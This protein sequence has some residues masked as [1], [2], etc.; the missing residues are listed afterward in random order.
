MLIDVNASIGEQTSPAVGSIDPKPECINGHHF[1]NFL[2]TFNLAAI[3]TIYNDG[4]YNSHTWTSPNNTTSR[5]DYIC[6]SQEWVNCSSNTL[7]DG[8]IDV[9]RSTDDHFMVQSTVQFQVTHGNTLVKRRR[10][11]YDRSALADHTKRAAF[12]HDLSMVPLPA[13]DVNVEDRTAYLNNCINVL[14]THH[15]PRARTPRRKF[16][17]DMTWSIMQ[18]RKVDIVVHRQVITTHKKHWLLPFFSAWKLETRIKGTTALDKAPSICA[19]VSTHSIMW[20]AIALL[21]HTLDKGAIRIRNSL[22]ED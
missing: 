13:S 15:F 22:E 11:N 18:Q 6:F 8:S 2:L 5:K 4:E 19:L 1:H 3:N 9:M 12:V 7:V 14:L 21:Q 10:D 17:S 16:V 20:R